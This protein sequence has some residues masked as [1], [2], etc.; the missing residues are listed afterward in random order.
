MA[1]RAM[2]LSAKAS[3]F[4]LSSSASPARSHRGSMAAADDVLA[5]EWPTAADPRKE[6]GTGSDVPGVESVC[7]SHDMVSRTSRVLMRWM[8]C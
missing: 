8:F 4:N 2:V 7:A 6:A 3:T 1:S 5:I